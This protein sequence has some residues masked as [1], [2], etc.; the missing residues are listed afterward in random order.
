MVF[1][2]CGLDVGVA[3]MTTMTVPVASGRL[4]QVT[5][6]WSGFLQVFPTLPD[7][8]ADHG[9]ASTISPAPWSCPTASRWPRPCPV[10]EV[11]DSSLSER[12]QLSGIPSAS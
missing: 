6:R 9:A 4:G 2:R 3:E 10:V 5:K 8:L 7:E 1:L 12:P 11:A